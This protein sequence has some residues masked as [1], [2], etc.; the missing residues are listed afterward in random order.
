MLYILEEFYRLYD[1]DNLELCYKLYEYSSL[2]RENEER[3]KYLTSKQKL[4]NAKNT[5]D[6]YIK[7]AFAKYNDADEVSR[8]LSDFAKDS[9]SDSEYASRY[10]TRDK[11][12]R[13]M[14][15][16]ITSDLVYRITNNDIYTYVDN[17]TKL[18]SKITFILPNICYYII[19]S[20]G[21][22]K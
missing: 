11:G 2:D 14:F 19:N 7:Y 5:I 15:K 20:R 6:S 13:D 22:I 8:R 21:A 3:F 17:I 1:D 9:I 12:Y 18:I 10:I 16:D 4:S